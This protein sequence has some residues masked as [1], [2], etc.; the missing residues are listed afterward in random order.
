MMLRVP[1]P[2]ELTPPL[3][4]KKIEKIAPVSLPESFQRARDIKTAEVGA[5]EAPA[6]ELRRRRRQPNEDDQPEWEKNPEERL[7]RISKH[8]K[9]RK[10]LWLTAGFLG[11]AAVAGL[12]VMMLRKKPESAVEPIAIAPIQE[13]V[14]VNPPPVAAVID[15]PQ[16][17]TR[18]ESELLSEML[19]LTRGFLE[20]DTVEKL[21]PFVRNATK[22]EEKIRAWYPD[23]KVP[24]PGMSA[25]NNKNALAYRGSLISLSVRTDE[26]EEK[27]I[28][29]IR[30]DDGLKIDWES[31]VAWSE[32]PWQQFISEKPESPTVFRVGLKMLE[33]Y[34]FDF[35]DEKKWQSYELRSPN[36][37]H[38]LY[39]YVRRDSALNDKIRPLDVKSSRLV[40]LKLK[41]VPGETKRNQVVIDSFVSDGWVEGAGE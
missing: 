20:A 14:L 5:N 18:S 29:F 38:V 40:T 22:I 10:G 34:N 31:Y 26:F 17:M 33:Y 13:E 27:Q 30:G 7:V 9:S 1:A 2:G 41:Y 15:L 12:A 11:S 19:P 36:G 3:V 4:E 39:G 35:S 32:M 21:L 28:A 24:A 16:E 23:G 37:E 8:R 25:F 6:G